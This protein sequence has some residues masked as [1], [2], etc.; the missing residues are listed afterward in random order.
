MTRN[1]IP[2]R[3]AQSIIAR[4]KEWKSSRERVTIIKP[5]LILWSRISAHGRETLPLSPPVITRGALSAC[6]QQLLQLSS[7]RTNAFPGLFFPRLSRVNYHSTIFL[8]PFSLALSSALLSWCRTHVCRKDN[9]A[10]A[11]VRIKYAPARLVTGFRKPINLIAAYWTAA[12]T[13]RLISSKRER[14]ALGYV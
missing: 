2:L 8:S 5:P 10:R 9:S 7:P 12:M 14:E 1:N 13:W 6:T 3:R 4:K 11:R